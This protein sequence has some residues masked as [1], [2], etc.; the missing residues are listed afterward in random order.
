M[1][2]W[3]KPTIG[4][5]AILWLV[6]AAMQVGGWINDIV[7]YCLLGIAF[8]WSIGIII[9]CCRERRERRKVRNDISHGS[10]PLKIV[11]KS[12]HLGGTT[13]DASLAVK[14]LVNPLEPVILGEC[15]VL[16]LSYSSL[17]PMLDRTDDAQEW[18][19]GEQLDKP[20]TYKLMFSVAPPLNPNDE[21]SIQIEAGGYECKSNPVKLEGH[22]RSIN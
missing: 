6:A 22:L 14:F 17:Y 18:K 15:K 5:N 8:L 21:V 2:K 19:V 4:G 9:Y 13:R 3:F 10:W 11:L 1:G 16:G 20:R 12:A 7:A